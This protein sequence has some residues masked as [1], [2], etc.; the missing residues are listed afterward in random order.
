M[1]IISLEV[2]TVLLTIYSLKYLCKRTHLNVNKMSADLAYLIR[3]LYKVAKHIDT[4]G[5]LFGLGN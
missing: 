5:V 3:E 2:Y 1:V 4:Y